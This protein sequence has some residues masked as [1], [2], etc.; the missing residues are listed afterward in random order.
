M[1]IDLTYRCSMGCSHC[2]SDC[3]PDGID[4]T[5]RVLE[6]VLEFYRKCHISMLFFLV[7][8]CLRINTF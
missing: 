1:L 5:P 3:K 2:M 4:M 7:E 8:R 6:D